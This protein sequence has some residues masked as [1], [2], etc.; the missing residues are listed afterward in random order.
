MTEKS[1]ECGENREERESHFGGPIRLP[2]AFLHLIR[3]ECA[4]VNVKADR[5]MPNGWSSP[6]MVCH[7]GSNGWQLAVDNNI[8]Y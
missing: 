8:N 7:R 3:K 4:C 2:E 6:G 1:N 5:G